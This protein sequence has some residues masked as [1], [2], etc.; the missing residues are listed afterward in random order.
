MVD[1]GGKRARGL[2]IT[3]ENDS[4]IGKGVTQTINN[5]DKTIYLVDNEAGIIA[6]CQEDIEL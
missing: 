6:V 3:I 1:V 5:G 2:D 4:V